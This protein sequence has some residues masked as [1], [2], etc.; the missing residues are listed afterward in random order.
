VPAQQ[1]IGEEWYQGTADA[2]R[3][4]LDLLRRRNYKD[5]LVLSGDHVYK[6]N[7]QQMVAF[8]RSANAGITIAAIRVP[9]EEAAGKLGVF[10]VDRNS[11]ILGFVE[12]PENPRTIPDEADHALASMGI[13]IFSAAALRETLEEE[14]DDFGKDIIPALIRK[15]H[16]IFLY[17]FTLENKIEDVT[18]QVENGRRQKVLIEKTRDSSYWRDVGSIDTYYEANMDIV[19]IDPLFNLYTERWPFRTFDRSFPPSKCIIGGKILESMV[20]DGC[21]ISGG[22]VQRSILSPGVIVERDALIEDSVI[23]D[24]VIIE[25]GARIQRA[26][27]DK[28]SVIRAGASVGYDAGL[29]TARGCTISEKGIVVVPRNHEINTS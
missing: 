10:E 27:V 26:I 11:K 19:G 17:D 21:I 25:P 4:N 2:I 6:M 28:E 8:H 9:V 1:K 20:S 22:T 18:V 12:K 16:E 3:Q 5:I 23:F 29:D 14:G 15:G 24:D 13:Y 7:Y